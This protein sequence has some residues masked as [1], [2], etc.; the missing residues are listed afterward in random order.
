MNIDL[1]FEALASTPRRKIL[2]FLAESSLTAGEIAQRFEMSR[3]A[4]SKHLSLLEGAGL[5]ASEKKGQ[6]VHYRLASDNLV[7]TLHTWLATVC[8]V[9]GPLRREGAALQAR[10]QQAGA[11][12]T[13]DEPD[14]GYAGCP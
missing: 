10:K 3:P 6:Y 1:V 13:D 5:V 11:A 2:A 4:L 12:G 8:P 9:G 14:P 7:A